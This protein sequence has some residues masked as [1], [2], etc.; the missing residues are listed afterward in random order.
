LTRLRAATIHLAFS[1]VVAALAALLVFVLWYPTPFREISGGRDLFFLVIAVDVVLGPLITFA[2]FDR[3]KD[4]AELTRD[5]GIVVALQLVGL[6]YGLYT[7]AQ[8][9]PALMALEGN[10]LRVVRAIDLSGADLNSAPPGLR[11]L[12][13]TGPRLIATRRPTEA[14]RLD[15]IDQGLAGKDLGMRPE[16]WLPEEG[17]GAAL[18]SAAMPLD[19]LRTL[20]AKRRVE[21]DTA[22]R[23]VT[24]D[25]QTRFGY[26]PILARRTDWT[27][28]VDRNTGRLVGYVPFEGF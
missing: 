24:G 7:V 15:T 19:R 8:A 5:L 20:N 28:L 4:R 6:A 9:R 1:A 17:V 23:A 14:E 2:V 12:P 25:D 27:A 11:T 26:L 22:I 16:F 3:R 10:R 21:L 18:A 13:L